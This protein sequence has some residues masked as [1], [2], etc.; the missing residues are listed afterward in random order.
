MRSVSEYEKQVLRGILSH[1][2]PKS[3]VQDLYRTHSLESLERILRLLNERK[4]K[5]HFFRFDAE[6]VSSSPYLPRQIPSMQQRPD[7]KSINSDYES[8]YSSRTADM[9]AEVSDEGSTCT[10]ENLDVLSRRLFQFPPNYQ[11]TASELQCAFKNLAR[12]YHPDRMQGCRKKYAVIQRAHDHL[13]KQITDSGPKSDVELKVEFNNQRGGESMAPRVQFGDESE[14]GFDVSRFN[15]HF[16]TNKFSDP[17]GG[18]SE[19]LQHLPTESP[20]KMSSTTNENFNAA[21]ESQKGKQITVHR[22]PC[23]LN[24]LFTQHDALDKSIPSDYSGKTDHLV[25]TDI[26]AALGTGMIETPTQGQSRFRTIDDLETFRKT[27][28]FTKSSEEENYAKEKEM[29]EIQQEEER[30]RRVFL[31]DQAIANSNM[32]LQ[33]PTLTLNR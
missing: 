20:A 18:Y 27:V 21:F 7:S 10:S 4:Q 15:A 32:R 1:N 31:R 26:K 12:Q 16:D 6:V 23:E 2:I 3:R 11:Y 24:S 19:W 29:F 30:Q 14:D 17:D 33:D 8:A 5:E 22:E 28:D 13:Q 9:F 25:Y